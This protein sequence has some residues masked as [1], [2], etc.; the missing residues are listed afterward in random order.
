MDLRRKEGNAEKASAIGRR[1]VSRK[2]KEN[3]AKMFLCL[4]WENVCQSTW[5]RLLTAVLP[6]S[7]KS[8]QFVDFSV[9]I[10][11]HESPKTLPF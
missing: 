6:L 8:S 7:R 10:S 2:E 3:K 9:A 11:E 5:L 1:K 4:L